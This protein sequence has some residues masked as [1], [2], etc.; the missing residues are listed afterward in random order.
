MALITVFTPTYNRADTLSRTYKS[1]CEQTDKD[2]IW[3]IVDDGSN[4][5]TRQLA[6]DWIRQGLIEIQYIYKENGGLH[7]GYNVAFANIE[8]ELNVCVDSDDFLPKNAIS[9]I[10]H[11]WSNCKDKTKLA[12]IIGLDFQL[13]DKPIGGEFSKIGDYHI[14]EMCGFHHGDTKIVCRTDLVKPLVPMPVYDGEKN[15][16][17]IYYYVQVDKDNKFQLVN[18]NLCYV[19][20]QES[21]MSANIFRQYR[22]S[23]QSFAQLRRLYL[24]MPYYSFK[25]HLRN[26][27]HYVSSCIFSKQWNGILK[28]PRPLMCLCM[29]PFGIM[30]NLY[31]RYKTK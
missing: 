9:I 30:L 27:I 20:Y 8:T 24:S 13:D 16:N 15:F 26:S 6:E 5:N 17:P 1:L 4:D 14:Y 22:N 19:D 3:L 7:T 28:S 11:V 12:G 31:I 23:P 21:G 10:H 25:T 2:F 29:I 18:E